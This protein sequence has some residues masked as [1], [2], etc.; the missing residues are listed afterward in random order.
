MRL[1]N[2]PLAIALRRTRA[3]IEGEADSAK[4]IRIVLREMRPLV[5]FDSASV[6][7]RRGSKLVIVGGIGFA[8]LDVLLGESFEI[9]NRDTPNGEVVHR[10]RPMIVGDT[11][12]YRS[13]R[14]G[15]H[16]GAG[17]RSWLGIPLI[18]GSDVVGIVTLDKGERD[19]YNDTHLQIA[20]A[21]ASL[22]ASRFGDEST[23]RH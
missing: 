7:K 4:A 6:Q 11:E 21:F 23:N 19:F 16:V 22:L 18:N 9:E 5:P 20:E 17:I 13:F 1:A 12:Q 3:A 10:R 14:R 2:G 15:L 8:D